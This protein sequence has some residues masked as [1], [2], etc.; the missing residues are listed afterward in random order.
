M[1]VKS[2]LIVL[3]SLIL[4][5]TLIFAQGTGK[6]L[7]VEVG[8]KVFINNQLDLVIGKNIGFITNHTSTLPGGIHLADTLVKIPGVKIGALFGPEHGIRGNN[9]DG[10]GISDGIDTKTGVKVFSLY[11]K[12]RK[13]TPE[14]LEGIDVLLFDIQDVGARFYTFISTMYYGIEAAAENNIPIIILDRPNP[15]G[16]LLVDGPIVLDSLKSFVGIAPI[17]IIHGMTVGELALMFN[18]ELWINSKNKADLTIIKMNNW[19]RNLFYDECGIEWIKPSPNLP[20]LENAIV[21]PGMCLFEA[22]N[23]S[24]GRGTQ[25][26]FLIIGAPYLNSQAVIDE[27][28]QKDFTS[29]RLF[30]TEFTPRAIPEMSNNPKYK[31]EL[32]QGIQIEVVNRNDFN[33]LR[34]GISLL[35]TIHKLYPA[36]LEF[37]RNSL[38][39][40]AGT[41]YLRSAILNNYDDETI[42]N[43]WENELNDFKI[44]RKKYLLY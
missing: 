38:E 17:P 27:M 40:L 24:E 10:V 28:S 41:T 3:Q 44:L 31:D 4:S 7:R 13:P 36:E 9:P 33:P 35:N 2:L 8:A 30:P 6:K 34:F 23:I 26:P 22:V 1:S 19:S 25:N 32:C 37:R 42:F 11:G 15:I 29:V 21:Y 39:R 5:F 12:Y 20:K 14:M 16:G 18:E 43:Y